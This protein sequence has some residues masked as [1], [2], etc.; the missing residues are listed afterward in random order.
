MGKKNFKSERVATSISYV[1]KFYRRVNKVK[2]SGFI[3]HIF[4]DSKF[5]GDF[6]ELLAACLFFAKNG[7]EGGR[8]I[9]GKV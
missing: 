2:M 4:F 1:N 5:Q 3:K 8:F 7:H 6:Y 9:L